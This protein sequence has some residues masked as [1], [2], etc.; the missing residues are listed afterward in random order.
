MDSRGVPTIG[1]G[2]AF[3]E[4]KNKEDNS[5]EWTIKEDVDVFL[6]FLC[7]PDSPIISSEQKIIIDGLKE[8]I[9]DCVSDIK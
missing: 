7:F 9:R 8:N 2:Y 1:V 5:T 6:R 4:K 3:L